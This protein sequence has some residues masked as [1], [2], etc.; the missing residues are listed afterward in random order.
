[1]AAKLL[2]QLPGMTRTSQS[3]MELVVVEGGRLR[4]MRKW[5]CLLIW[6]PRTIEFGLFPGTV[7]IAWTTFKDCTAQVET[8]DIA[9]L[10]HVY[11]NIYIYIYIHIY[12]YMVPPPPVIYLFW[13]RLRKCLGFRAELGRSA[14]LYCRFPSVWGVGLRL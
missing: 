7:L 5:V 8:A 13:G 4:F 6:P 10:I 14:L 11:T 3:N 9:V 12:I 1:M 2:P